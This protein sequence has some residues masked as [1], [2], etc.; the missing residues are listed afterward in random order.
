[1]TTFAETRSYT[2]PHVSREAAKECSP[3]RKPWE[4]NGTE[5]SP[6]GTAEQTANPC[7]PER[8][9]AASKASGQTQSKDPL[10]SDSATGKARSFRIAVRF[11]D[12][13][14]TE[15]LHGP[16]REAA[17]WDGPARQCRMNSWKGTTGSWEPTHAS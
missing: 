15:V 4:P 10:N 7:H 9:L 14:D 6:V 16:S 17:T 2:I 8:S 3:R 5:A 12:D 13:Q 11:F 1:M